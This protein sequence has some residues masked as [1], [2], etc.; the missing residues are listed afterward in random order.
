[1]DRIE[2]RNLTGIG[3][4]APVALQT[5]ILGNLAGFLGLVERLDQIGAELALFLLAGLVAPVGDRAGIREGVVE[6]L[7]DIDS[8]TAEIDADS[9]Q[10]ILRALMGGSLASPPCSR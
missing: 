7:L 8:A 6:E 5:D 1:V 9:L 10:L 3:E 4:A 2:A